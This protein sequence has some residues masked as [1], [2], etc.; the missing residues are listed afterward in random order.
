MA[1]LAVE[2]DTEILIDNQLKNLGWNN[3]PRSATRNVYQQRVKTEEQKKR[4]QGKRPD[5]ILYPSNSNDPLAII[6]AKRPGQNIHEALRQGAWY[7]ER[8]EAPIVFATDGVFTKTVHI[9]INKPLMLNGEEVDELI[10]EVLALRYLNT[11]EVSTLDKKVIRSRGE[12]INIFGTVNNLLREEG[13]QKGLE[14][15]TEFANILFLKV[16]SEIEDIKEELG[17]KSKIDIAYRW[18]YFRDKKGQELLSYVSD[19]VIKWFS[20]EYQD[21]NIFQPLQIKHPENLKAIIE[22]LDGL[23]LTDINADI[24]GDAFEYFIRSYSASNPSDLGEIFTPR[25]IVK[26]MVRLINPKIGER[27][28]DPFCGTGGMLIVAFKYLMDTMPRNQKNVETLKKYTVYG[29]DLTK[30]A[31][32]AKMNMI[33]TGDG[34]NNVIRRDSLANPVDNEYEIVITNMPFAQKTRYGDKYGIPSRN[35]DIVC[36]Q[37]CF[38]ALKDGGRM[39][40]I[41]PEGFLA[42]TNNKA[43]EDVR[44]FLLKNATLKSVISLPRGAFEPYNRT[45][46]DILYFIDA[47]TS[48]TKN[49]YW[50]F[51]VKNDGYTLDKK[52]HHIEGDNDLE[53][54]LSENNLDNQ[55][56]DYLLAIGISKIEVDKIRKNNYILNAAHYRELLQYSI[57][58]YPL[59][60]FDDL[61]ELS[62]K[63]KIGSSKDAP[64]MS[65]TMAHGLIDQSEKFIKRIAS[66]D[67]SNYKKVYQNELVVGF[68]IDE[69]VL[70]FQFKYSFAAVSPAYTIWRLKRHD[71]DLKFLDILLRSQ[72]MRNVYKSKMQGA[73]DRRRS[74][75]RDIFIEIKIPIP[76]KGIQK[77]I[78][79]KQQEIERAAMSIKALEQEISHSLDKLWEKKAKEI[80]PNHLEDF[81]ETLRRAAILPKKAQRQT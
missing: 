32:I 75:P 62:G 8:L 20:R 67:I 26:T 16:L 61:F 3:N 46:T 59:V 55:S 71:I 11:N 4:L 37:H 5:Y 50:F 12:L 48:R 15:F 54:V 42:N 2:R 49:H 29:A 63:E 64:V 24:K 30:T 69:G 51:D 65:I 13:L 33:L 66:T 14:R 77:A 6:E 70:G 81:N 22:L 10:R 47:K 9:K 31:S 28:Y 76:S 27:I 18:N 41:V 45:K 19:T 34:H 1:Q 36:P 39:A 35:G 73:V 21:D 43:Y 72:M 68:P 74:I 79:K 56:E 53:L 40:I 58:K 7:A 80:N 25:H 44:K 52:R 38:R 78:V 17:E 57:L 23:Q 60:K